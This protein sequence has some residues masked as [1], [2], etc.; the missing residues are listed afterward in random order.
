[1]KQIKVFALFN[2]IILLSFVI[3]FLTSSDCRKNN[4]FFCRNNNYKNIT[5]FSVEVETTTEN[6][7]PVD[8]SGQEVDLDQI[9]ELTIQL[10]E[11]LDI[12]IPRDCFI[13]K[14]APNWYNSQ[15]SGQEVFPCNT[16]ISVCLAKEDITIDD[17]CLLPLGEECP[18]NKCRC[19][20][21]ATIQDNFI[22]VTTPDLRLYKAEL[23]RMVL[24]INNPWTAEYSHCLR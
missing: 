18:P 14:V 10:E 2:L 7:I 15:C 1:M 3:L 21:R 24:G 17:L 4:S 22:I 8:T 20:C 9:D 6:G 5:E 13:V 12:V 23:A 19:A 16:P 11:C